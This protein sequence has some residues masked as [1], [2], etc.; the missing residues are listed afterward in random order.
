[1]LTTILNGVLLPLMAVWFIPNAI[2]RSSY[3]S[4]QVS[5]NLAIVFCVTIIV[6]FENK[7]VNSIPIA[8]LN[9]LLVYA[10]ARVSYYFKKRKRDG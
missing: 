4:A 8:I 3:L 10:G 2:E 6:H 1:M 7:G 9:S 5:I